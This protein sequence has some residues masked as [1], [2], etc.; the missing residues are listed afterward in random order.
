MDDYS[1]A[2]LGADGWCRCDGLHRPGF[3]TLLRDVLHHFSYTG[4]PAYHFH[5]YH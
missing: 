1:Y 3:P 4:F 5:P 2:T